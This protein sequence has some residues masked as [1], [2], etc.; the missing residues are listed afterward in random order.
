MGM[1]GRKCAHIIYYLVYGRIATSSYINSL[2]VQNCTQT[3]KKDKLKSII[4][5]KYLTKKESRPRS[6]REKE[7]NFKEN[8]SYDKLA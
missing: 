8:E 3:G 2:F 7:D 5:L 1:E 4:S 6:P